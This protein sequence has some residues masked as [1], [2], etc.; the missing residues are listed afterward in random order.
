MISFIYFNT[1]CFLSLA[2]VI[3]GRSIQDQ[4][5]HSLDFGEHDVNVCTGHVLSID[6]LRV[7][8]EFGPVLPVQFFSRC[9]CVSVNGKPF[10][11]LLEMLHVSALCH[12]GSDLQGKHQQLLHSNVH[13]RQSALMSRSIDPKKEERFWFGSVLHRS[14][15]TC[16]FGQLFYQFWWKVTTLRHPIHSCSC[17]SQLSPA[18]SW[19]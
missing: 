19:Y 17:G 14:W 15:S 4:V 10:K 12:D 9:F 5:Q 11:S 8:A 2:P 16:L 18:H 6:D 3:P 7:L 1:T 13:W